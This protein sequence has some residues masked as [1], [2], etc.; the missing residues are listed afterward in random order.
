MRSRMGIVAVLLAVGVL[1]AHADLI[2]T[3]LYE[4]ESAGAYSAQGW[5]AYGT[6]T[7]DSGSTTSAYVGTYARFHAFNMGATGVTWGVGDKSP[8]R[9]N[10]TYGFPD[11]NAFLGLSAAVKLTPG[12][13]ATE[14]STV[15]LLLAIGTD[16]WASVEPL[17][18]SYERVEAR[19]TDLIPQG[20]AL[21]PITAAQL[22]DPNLQIKFVLRKGSDVGKG[23][24]RYDHICAWTPE[25]GSLLLLVVG[26]AGLR[27]R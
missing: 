19:F 22:A 14:I 24:L 8:L 16:E 7:T 3:V 21:A 1:A 5:S 6:G 27:R 15:E 25:P 2:E 20:T 12:S 11:L 23:T 4:F 13:P 9:S 10:A 18:T 17:T 26:L